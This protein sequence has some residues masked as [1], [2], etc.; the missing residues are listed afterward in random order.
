MEE[1]SS[2]VNLV[3]VVVTAAIAYHG[4]TYRDEKGETEAGHLFFGCIALVYSLSIL[5]GD[6]LDVF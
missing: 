6:I 1:S 5:F 3:F 2:L 4:L